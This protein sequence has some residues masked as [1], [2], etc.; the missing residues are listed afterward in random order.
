V[1][2]GQKAGGP[3]CSYAATAATGFTL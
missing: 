1:A 3:R 2:R